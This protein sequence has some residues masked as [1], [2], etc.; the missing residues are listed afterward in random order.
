MHIYLSFWQWMS[1]YLEE[2]WIPQ[3]NIIV[4]RLQ[5]TF[6]PIMDMDMGSTSN[7]CKVSML[8]NWNTIDACF[9]SSSWQITSRGTFAVTCIGVVLLV[10]LM[11]FLRRIAKEYDNLILRQFQRHV[12][13]QSLLHKIEIES[14]CC[15]TSSNADKRVAIFRPTPLQQLTRAVIHAVGFGVGYIVMLLAM[16]FNGY[17]IISIFIGA[18]IGKYV[19]D[20]T[21]TAVEIRSPDSCR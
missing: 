15:L 4:L 21:A 11:E 9:L 7:D 2:R 5:I 19:C 18:G 12:E 13:A 1:D 17:I 6:L 8:W 20:W 3:Y 14:S 10:V 16:Y